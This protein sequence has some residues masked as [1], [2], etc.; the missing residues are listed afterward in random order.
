MKTCTTCGVEK[1][2]RCFKLKPRVLTGVRYHNCIKCQNEF[3]RLHKAGVYRLGACENCGEKFDTTY[4]TRRFCKK[5]KTAVKRS[6]NSYIKILI[7]SGDRGLVRMISPEMV[8]EKKLQL[9]I[10]RLVDEKSR[11][12]N[13]QRDN[14]RH[15]YLLS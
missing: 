13:A 11:K 5:C 2:E 7:A 8:E 4:K 3:K 14:G 10:K 12:S 9:K 6:A 1:S 15:D